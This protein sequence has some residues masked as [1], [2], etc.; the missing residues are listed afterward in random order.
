MNKS[1]FSC[2]QNTTGFSSVIA[3]FKTVI[4]SMLITAVALIILAALVAY[5][6]VS[7]KTAGICVTVA[8]IISVFAS[9]F[10]TSKKGK[11]RGYLSGASAGIIYVLIML[12]VG[13]LAFGSVSLGTETIKTFVIAVVSGA[14][15][16]VFGVNFK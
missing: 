2:S 7:E 3:T 11:R 1:N 16:G 12:V 9:G 10:I 8:M 6:P 15:G 14:A 13:F 4:I 5:G